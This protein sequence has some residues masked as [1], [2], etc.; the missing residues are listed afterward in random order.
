LRS[1]DGEGAHV[2]RSRCVISRGAGTRL[3]LIDPIFER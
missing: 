2:S 3:R 1:P